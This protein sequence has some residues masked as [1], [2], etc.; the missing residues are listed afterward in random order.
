MVWSGV[1]AGRT[2]FGSNADGYLQAVVAADSSPANPAER[3]GS[4][5]MATPAA[6]D[7]RGPLR[8]RRAPGHRRH[9]RPAQRIHRAG[10]RGPASCRT[11]REL[12]RAKPTTPGDT[13]AAL[14]PPTARQ[15]VAKL[16]AATPGVRTTSA[17]GCRG[18]RKAHPTGRCIRCK[19]HHLP[20]VSAQCRGCTIAI[21]EDGVDAEGSGC[22]QL[23]FGG[24]FAPRLYQRAGA[25]GYH[26]TKWRAVARERARR[27]PLLPAMSEN[28]VD[29]RQLL[30]L[31]PPRTWRAV[32]RADGPVPTLTCGRSS[33]R[34]ARRSCSRAEVEW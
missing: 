29:P 10:P 1:R 13:V 34:A 21:I 8:R 18:W 25:L 5:T 7:P 4:R 15:T 14:T 24:A 3:D 22:T 23:W 17:V 28:L 11:R 2:D 6:S 33:A 31:D 19:R 32:A 20:L 27:P 16:R 12:V 9:R 30:L 26:P